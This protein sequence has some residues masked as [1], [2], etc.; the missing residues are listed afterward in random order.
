MKTTAM[1]SLLA[2]VAMMLLSPGPARA[3]D[4]M[5]PKLRAALVKVYVETQGWPISA[6]WQKGAPRSRVQ[7][8]VVVRPGLV[9]TPATG[10]ANH[11]MIEVSEANSAR[12]FPAS[13]VR[14]NYGADLAVIKIE[15]PSLSERLKPLEL[16]EPITIDDEFT[17][18]QLGGSDLVERFTGHVQKVYTQTPRLMLNVKTTLADSGNGQPVIV[19]GKLAGL[20]NQTRASRQEAQVIAVETIN[21]FLTDMEEGEYVGWP[22]RGLW[23]QNLL[24]D[25]LREFHLVPDDAHGV[26]VSR[27]I[28]G[29]TGS[30][31]VV[32]GDVITHLSGF[33]LDDEGKYLDP[34]HGRLHMSNL[35]YCQP[36]AGDKLKAKILR[37]GKPLAVEIPVPAWPL[38][39]QRV[40]ANYYDRRPP[41][42]LVAGLVVLELSRYSQVGDSQLRQFQK[43]VWWDPP[44]ARKRIVY[45]SHVLPDPANKGL[46]AISRIAILTVN[47]IQHEHLIT[48]KGAQRLLSGA[49]TIS[50]SKAPARF[51]IELEGID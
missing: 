18:W 30:G 2:L 12:R 32:D 25:D 41:Y 17:V 26:V 7:R 50:P 46:D 35:L 43:T 38:P 6:P 29:K 8:G 23:T 37:Q 28:E 31:G 3:E 11:I 51:E 24:R 21:H 33:D 44:T 34:V 39:E 10:I 36:Y 20:V 9:L 45:A 27:V 22:G 15:D 49:K 42:I 1:V 47:G 16:H 5:A 19:D 48:I 13:L 14:V 4:E 40:P